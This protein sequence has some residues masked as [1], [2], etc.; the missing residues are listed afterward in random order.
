MDEAGPRVL[1]VDD[2]RFF[3]EQISD[4]LAAAS[5]E[6]TTATTGAEALERGRG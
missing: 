5:I 2:E 4:A 6:C 3:R 1:V